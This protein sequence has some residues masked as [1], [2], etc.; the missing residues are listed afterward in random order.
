MSRRDHP[1]G[2][3]VFVIASKLSLHCYKSNR[4]WDEQRAVPMFAGFP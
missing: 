4:M 3:F 2:Q 1:R